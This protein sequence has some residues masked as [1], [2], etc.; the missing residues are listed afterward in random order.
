MSGTVTV[1]VKGRYRWLP[2]SLSGCLFWFS[3]CDARCC[4]C[5]S[6]ARATLEFKSSFLWPKDQQ[7]F[8][9][10]QDSVDQNTQDQAILEPLCFNTPA[11]HF[12]LKVF[13]M[14]STHSFNFIHCFY[15]KTQTRSNQMV[16]WFNLSFP[17]TN[18]MFFT[19]ANAYVTKANQVIYRIEITKF[20]TRAL[21]SSRQMH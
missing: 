4:A 8:I 18:L 11:L 16:C 12:S 2:V 9:G 14:R 21:F 6:N 7:L 20:S 10:N 19:G 17:Q 15:L 13:S 1:T 3:A 5:M